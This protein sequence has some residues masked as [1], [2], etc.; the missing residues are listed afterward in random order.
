MCLHLFGIREDMTKALLYHQEAA[1]PVD[2]IKSR[3]LHLHSVPPPP[4]Y[5]GYA[6]PSK[7]DLKNQRS[8]LVLYSMIV[9]LRK[10]LVRGAADAAPGSERLHTEVNYWVRTLLVDAAASP[11]SCVPRICHLSDAASIRYS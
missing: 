5:P 1:Q 11:T 10:A 7:E 9:S 6:T 2:T 8:R 4:G 3:L